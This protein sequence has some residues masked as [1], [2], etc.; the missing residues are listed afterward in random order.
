MRGMRFKKVCKESVIMFSYNVFRTGKEIL[1]AVCD[2][3]ILGKNFG[4]A[5]FRV[6]E[7]FYGGN[8]CSEDELKEI[9]DEATII[10]AVGNKIIDF[11][12]RENII[13]EKGIIKIGDVPH[14]QVFAI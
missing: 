4:D 9:L 6:N 1:V 8:S 13:D 10:N 7:K 12:F 11:L 2:R 5:D 14:A 3:E